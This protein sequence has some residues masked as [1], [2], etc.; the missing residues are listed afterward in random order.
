MFSKFSLSEE[1]GIVFS[2]NEEEQRLINY[3]AYPSIKEKRKKLESKYKIFLSKEPLINLLYYTINKPLK[4]KPDEENRFKISKD[5]LNNLLLISKEKRTNKE[6]Y[7]TKL[8]ELLNPYH[9]AVE[10]QY[11]KSENLSEEI[12]SKLNVDKKEKIERGYELSQ[13]EF[14][15]KKSQKYF[16]Y[17]LEDKYNYNL[18]SDNNN[19]RE[20]VRN[21]Y[22]LVKINNE[23][24]GFDKIMLL[25]PDFTVEELKLLVKFFYKGQLG[26]EVVDNICLYLSNY[27]L[28]ITEDKKT[29]K[30]L[31]DIFGKNQEL[32]INITADY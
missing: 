28:E 7:K 1:S 19:L 11:I 21:K 25:N 20:A 23:L 16:G 30:E 22:V 6:I 4:I 15:D 5:K 31:N 14:Y 32:D 24:D 17:D 9:L 8:Y 18:Q 13:Y 27:D 29:M 10:K 12:K 2:K 3:E 26:Y